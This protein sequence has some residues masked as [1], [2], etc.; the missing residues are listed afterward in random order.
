[1]IKRG[2]SYCE[3]NQKRQQFQVNY[4]LQINQKSYSINEFRRSV[5][6]YPQLQQLVFRKKS[7][8]P[9]LDEKSAKSEI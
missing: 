8:K 4:S 2:F 6:D 1:M 7:F 5:R 3:S 9:V